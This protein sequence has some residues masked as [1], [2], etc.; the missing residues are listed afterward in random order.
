[1]TE[2]QDIA[3]VVIGRNEGAR[4]IG[5][6]RSLAGQG[7]RLVY[8]D[9]GSTDDS[10]AEAR[11]L[12]A[13]VVELDQSV[14]FT[15][16]RGRNAG[17]DALRGADL[18]RFVQFIDGDCRVEPGWLNAAREALKSNPDLA[19]VTG[20][21]REMHPDHSVYN[22][23]C[24]FEWHRPAGEIDTCG[25]DMMV[26]STAFEQV[27]GF[28]PLVIAAE[29]D[30]FCIRIRST[31]GKIQRLP[32][33]MTHHDAAMTRFSQWWKR[34]ERAG[35]GFAQVG[36]MHPPHF[37][38]ET[39][40]V[41]FYGGVLPL[42][43]LLGLWFACWLVIVVAAVYALSYVR[44]ARGLR[45]EGLARSKALHHALFLSLSKFPNLIGMIRFYWRRLCGS[46]MRLIEY[47]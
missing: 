4:L 3:A 32:H 30:E 23:M 18:P 19:I 43:A 16:A 42:L 20:W 37:Q 36:A 33:V 15:A 11:K 45:R 27:G 24:D 28:D 14:P 40:R 39:R 44:T 38:R 34:A 10:V 41:L 31:G 6:L 9:S 22:A 35:H 46:R 1:M 21:R 26:R 12:G 25:G 17:F 7:A 47:K 29:D 5:C 13:V 2:R 8:V